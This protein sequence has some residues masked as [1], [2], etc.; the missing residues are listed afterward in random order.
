MIR[1]VAREMEFI[2]NAAFED[3]IPNNLFNE[4]TQESL[5][6]PLFSNWSV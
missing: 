3:D 5:D 6:H 2:V 1:G 4:I